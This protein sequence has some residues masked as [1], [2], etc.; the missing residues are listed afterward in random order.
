VITAFGE[1]FLK[2]AD[3]IF[4]SPKMIRDA[5]DTVEADIHSM[6]E[7]LSALIKN[8]NHLKFNVL[9]PK[10]TDEMY[11]DKMQEQYKVDSKK[12]KELLSFGK[13]FA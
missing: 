4:S 12:N 7:Y 1:N 13:K 2:P 10:D 3:E 6:L 5:V 8:K 11:V 9:D